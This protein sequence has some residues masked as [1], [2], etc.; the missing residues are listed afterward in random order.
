[1]ALGE[2]DGADGCLSNAGFRLFAC[3]TPPMI[4]DLAGEMQ[5]I[6]SVKS[7]FLSQSPRIL[8]NSV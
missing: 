2:V 8:Q 1:M 6:H 5:R 7:P 3:Q 4:R